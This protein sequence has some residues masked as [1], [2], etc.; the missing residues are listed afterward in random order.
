M[1]PCNLHVMAQS[2]WTGSIEGGSLPTR[3]YKGEYELTVMESYAPQICSTKACGM[4]ASSNSLG[5]QPWSTA[6][7]PCLWWYLYVQRQEAEQ[8]KF[9]AESPAVLSFVS[10][11]RR[12]MVSGAHL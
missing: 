6:F 9:S 1:L 5:Q 11:S 7:Q 4:P 3:T 10:N 2:P 8:C 12:H